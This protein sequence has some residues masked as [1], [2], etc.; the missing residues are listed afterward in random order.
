ML[1]GKRKKIFA[2]LGLALALV[3]ACTPTPEPT[4]VAPTAIVMAPA[5][6][7]N[8]AANPL[9]T[10]TAA[11]PQGAISVPTQLA[12]VTPP[13][14]PQQ[15]FAPT[16]APTPTQNAP[17][18]NAPT[19]PLPTL[20]NQLSPSVTPLPQLPTR[21]AT[22]APA[23][24]ATAAP[25]QISRETLGGKILFKSTRSGGK[26]PNNFKWFVMNG[27]GSG[28]VQVDAAR[29]KAL[30]QELKG[31]EGYSPDRSMLVLGERTCAPNAH[32]D[33]YVG[34]PEMILNRS[35]GQWTPPGPRWYRADNPAWSPRGDWIAFIWNRDNE[36]TK[37]IFKGD[38][39]KLNQ[40]FKR[41]TDFGGRRDTKEL[42]FAPDGSLLA[43]AT[44]DGPR[45]QIWVL[46]ADA[47]NPNDAAAR[48]ISQ[49]DAD[50]WDPLWI[51]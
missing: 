43:F 32:C 46:N 24:T 47:E 42:T 2:V 12:T 10:G 27:D 11:A 26:Y 5:A 31:Q 29:A 38:P 21:P 36:R 23:Q 48:N 16:D 22:L 44:Q 15:P 6:Q 51:K 25:T 30:Y 33:L 17:I 41:L 1:F 7:A 50:D 20:S 37:N 3:A 28:V 14:S 35:Q 49:V 34:A 45:W 9:P 18:E 8:N 19:A 40:D 13:P 39:Y 4:V